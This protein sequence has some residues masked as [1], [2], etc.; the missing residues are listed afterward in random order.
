MLEA[1]TTSF[2]LHLKVHPARAVRAYNASI[3]LAVMIIPTVTSIAEDAIRAVPPRF[4]QGALALGATA[5]LPVPVEQKVATL[6]GP[7]TKPADFRA[8]MGN[9]RCQTGQLDL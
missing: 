7:E 2:Q 3:I 4:K 6:F 8:A 1:A 5:Y 9:I